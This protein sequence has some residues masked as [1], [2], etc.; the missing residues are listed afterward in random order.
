MGLSGDVVVGMED[1]TLRFLEHKPLPCSVLE[2]HLSL[3]V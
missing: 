3:Q 2:V 1:A